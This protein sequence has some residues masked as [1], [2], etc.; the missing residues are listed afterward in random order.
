M[1]TS[2]APRPPSTVP[3]AGRPVGTIRLARSD[4]P[5]ALPGGWVPRVQRQTL[6][7]VQ[8]AFAPWWPRQHTLNH[9]T[10]LYEAR[11]LSYPRTDS[12]AFPTRDR[13]EAVVWVRE[14]VQLFQDRGW[15]MPR[16]HGWVADPQ[17]FDDRRVGAH[18]G[19][20]PVFAHAHPMGL[21]LAT[22]T[23]EQVV[24]YRAVVLGFVRNLADPTIRRQRL[25]T[26]LLNRAVRTA[27][28]GRATTTGQ[29]DGTGPV[30]RRRL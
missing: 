19:L 16:S 1:S 26:L 10:A 6:A 14:A 23:G 20:H 22:L 21:V 4:E 3:D 17:R 12:E 28:N 24:L 15:P 2:T 7:G 5:L 8:D 18:T 30:P 29:P 25:E 13:D 9:L 11:C 27:L